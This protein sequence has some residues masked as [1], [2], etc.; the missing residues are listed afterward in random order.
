MPPSTDTLIELEVACRVLG[1]SLDQSRTLCKMLNILPTRWM[2][3]TFIDRDALEK[4]DRLLN[5]PFAEQAA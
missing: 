5:P 1:I 3:E 4:L 2:D